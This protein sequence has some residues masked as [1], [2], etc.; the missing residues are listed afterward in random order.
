VI[1]LGQRTEL[2]SDTTIEW[3]STVTVKDLQAKWND[4]D[5]DEGMGGTPREFLEVSDWIPC[6][7]I[8][9]TMIWLS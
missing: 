2:V 6:D 9:L 8:P 5:F 4:V 1:S 3:H 7:S